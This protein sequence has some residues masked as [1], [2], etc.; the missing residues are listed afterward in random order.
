[1][2]ADLDNS[3]NAVINADETGRKELLYALHAYVKLVMKNDSA[4]EHLQTSLKSREV[5]RVIDKAKNGAL[6]CY[7]EMT[8]GIDFTKEELAPFDDIRSVFNGAQESTYEYLISGHASY[9]LL[10]F[11]ANI[12]FN[13]EEDLKGKYDKYFHE[14]ANHL[15]VGLGVV[16]QTGDFFKDSLAD[17]NDYFSTQQ[18]TISMQALI[19]LFAF[20]YIEDMQIAPEVKDIS[21]L[22]T[23]AC[24]EYDFVSFDYPLCELNLAR[25]FNQNGFLLL[26]NEIKGT[27]SEVISGIKS[28]SVDVNAALLIFDGRVLDLDIKKDSRPSMLLQTLLKNPSNEWSQDQITDDWGDEEAF[29]NRA[30]YDAAVALNKKVAEKT[31]IKD[32]LLL[33]GM[34]SVQINPMYIKS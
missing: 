22:L 8:D 20:R 2:T 29:S 4:T 21:A 15:W 12:L 34:H 24:H 32:F 16:V 23:L 6:V 19:A 1:M 25:Y 30:V 18:Q 33:E 10:H 7:T 31:T 27:Y 17:L 13:R 14:K 11:V 26:H 28:L 5:E 3:Y 9:A